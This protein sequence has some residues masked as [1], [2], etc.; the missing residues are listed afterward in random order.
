MSSINYTIAL[1]NIL[2][3]CQL[4]Y[5]VTVFTPSGSF[6]ISTSLIISCRVKLLFFALLCLKMAL[7]TCAIRCS[8]RYLMEGLLSKTLLQWIPGLV[9]TL[10][11][12]VNIF[13]NRFVFAS[14]FTKIKCIITYLIVLL[15]IRAFLSFLSRNNE[16]NSKAVFF[17]FF[18]CPFSQ[19]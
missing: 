10:F 6:G 13:Q 7:F 11:T 18:K 1:W 2:R 9:V 16:Y 5:E 4:Q 17:F 19:I 8:I 15:E 3:P 12:P 14:Q